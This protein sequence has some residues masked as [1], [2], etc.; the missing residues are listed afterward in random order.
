MVDVSTYA[1]LDRGVSRT[2]GKTSEFDDTAAGS[3]SFTL[4]NSD[5]RFTPGNTLSALATTV[6][7]GMVVCWQL[8]SRLVS[9]AIRSIEPQFPGAQSAWAQVL[10]TCDDQLASAARRTMASPFVDAVQQGATSFLMWPLSD[11]V[12]VVAPLETTGN[13]VGLLQ[14]VGSSGSVFG[15]TA[16]TGLTTATQL[17]LKDQLRSP[18]GAAWPTFPFVYTGTSAGFYSCWI[19]PTNLTTSKVTVAVSLSGVATSMQFGYSS[20]AYFIRNGDA[21]TTAT[22]TLT[23]VL[24]HFVSMGLSYSGTTLTMTLYVDGTSRGTVAVTGVTTF[25]YRAPT[26]ITVTAVK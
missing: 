1:D 11:A 10:V 23:N 24:P 17:S 2:W 22:Y 9:G 21:G 5:G 19:T 14:L 18:S 26:A 12:G 15:S 4:D 8:G 13:G 20:T 7:E 25:A 6:A 16:I 3:F